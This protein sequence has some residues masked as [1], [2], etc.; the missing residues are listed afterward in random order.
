MRARAGCDVLSKPLARGMNWQREFFFLVGTVLKLP[1]E[2]ANGH[3]DKFGCLLGEIDYSLEMHLVLR[4]AG[5]L[6]RQRLA[7]LAKRLLT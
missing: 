5:M 6:P 4:E 3:P 2:D 7:R 1:M